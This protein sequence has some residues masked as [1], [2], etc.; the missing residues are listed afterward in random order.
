MGGDSL[1]FGFQFI[2]FFVGTVFWLLDCIPIVN[3]FTNAIYWV[4]WLCVFIFKYKPLI[5]KIA[6]GGVAIGG[7]YAKIGVISGFAFVL[8]EIPIVSMVPWDL[9]SNVWINQLTKQLLARIEE[10]KKDTDKLGQAW[11]SHQQ[12]FPGNKR[13]AQ[14]E[15]NHQSNENG[16]D[17]N[18]E[19]SGLAEKHEPTDVA[20]A[21]A[22]EERKDRLAA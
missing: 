21:K 13:V 1:S 9:I 17:P 8:G 2:M 6:K 19:D 10:I 16:P 4:I 18:A 5:A 20:G 12:N 7:I 22:R 3:V 14:T 15:T 11:Q